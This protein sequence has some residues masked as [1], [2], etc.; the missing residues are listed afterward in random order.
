MVPRGFR[1]RVRSQ[2]SPWRC[3]RYPAAGH[4]TPLRG[5]KSSAQPGWEGGDETLGHDSQGQKP[6]RTEDRQGPEPATSPRCRC[7]LRGCRAPPENPDVCRTCRIL[8]GNL[9]PPGMRRSHRENRRGGDVPQPSVCQGAFRT[10]FL[11]C[12]SCSLLLVGFGRAAGRGDEGSSRLVD[13]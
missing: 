11:G 13:S 12:R 8:Y 3:A 9:W 1:P 2:Q 4:Q 5:S 7:G 6:P 10:I